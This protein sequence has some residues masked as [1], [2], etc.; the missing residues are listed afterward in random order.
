MLT[1]MGNFISWVFLSLMPIEPIILIHTNTPI[2]EWNRHLY[3][4]TNFYNSLFFSRIFK[5]SLKG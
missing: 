1:N 2:A 4:Y 3:F 5:K